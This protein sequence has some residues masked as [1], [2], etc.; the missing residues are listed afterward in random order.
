MVAAIIDCGTNTFNLLIAELD[1]YGKYKILLNTKK[2]VK[3]GE[4]GL[5][6]NRITPNAFKRGID[7][8]CEFVE[9]AESYNADSIKA[10]ATSAVRSSINGPEFVKTVLEKTKIIIQVL[11]GD[12]EAQY[13][14]KGVN[15]AIG[16]I[17]SPVLIMDIGGGST[18]FIIA[19]DEKVLWKKSFDLGASRLLQEFNPQDPITPDEIQKIKDYFKEILQPLAARIKKNP[20]QTLI[21][22]SGSFESLADLIRHEKS[23]FSLNGHLYQFEI[24]DFRNQHKKLIASTESQRRQ[25]P[26]LVEYRVDTIVFATILI[27]HVIKRFKIDNL[28]YSS[29]SLKE[30]ILADLITNRI[31]I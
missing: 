11:N 17:N 9:L 28:Y 16:K 20:V 12:T 30:G 15:L 3:L 10:F 22:C 14:F 18:E 4:G 29:Y 26:G 6:N 24:D 2:S 7:T 1:I 19:E 21:G 23:E 5:I 25:M 27:R 8:F 13:I 31:A